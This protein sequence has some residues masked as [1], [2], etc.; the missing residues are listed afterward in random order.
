MI[1]LSKNRSQDYNKDQLIIGDKIIRNN[2]KRIV[3][4]KRVNNKIHD[5]K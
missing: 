3:I 2:I 1:G 4:S 5:R